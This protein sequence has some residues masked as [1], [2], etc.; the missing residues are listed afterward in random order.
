[1]KSQRILSIICFALFLATFP[2]CSRWRTPELSVVT[3]TNPLDADKS[4]IRE[5]INIE[6]KPSGYQRTTIKKTT[7]DGG[8][9]A[10]QV[11]QETVVIANRLSEKMT[12]RIEATALQKRD[13]TF[14]KGQ[15][16][17][18]LDKNPMITLFVPDQSRTKLD[19]LASTVV[20]DPKTGGET[21]TSDVANRSIA[22]QNGTAGHFALYFSLWNNPLQPEE[23]RSVSYFD[24][25]FEQNVSVELSAGRISP[26]LL[27]GSEIYLLLVKAV[28]NY[29]T[30]SGKN[31][32]TWQFWMD[33]KGNMVRTVSQK[34]QEI[35]WTLS[36]ESKVNA[37]LKNAGNLNL[38]LY[39]IVPVQGKIP[40]PRETKRVAFL[41]QYV[42]A[43]DKQSM[44]SGF[45]E[46]I[47][48]TAFQTV[49]AENVAAWTVA[50]TGSSPQILSD[51]YGSVIP[52]AEKETS[53]PGDL[54]R[55]EWIQS[56]DAAVTGLANIATEKNFP[57]WD[58]ATD[59]E[60]FVHEKMRRVNYDSSLKSA[61]EA[62]KTLTGDSAAHA[63][64]LAALAR[65]KNI[66]SRIVAGLVYTNTSTGEGVLV[67][68]FWTELFI[69]E[70]WRP[71]D[72]TLGRG[73]A[74]ASR[75]VLARSNLAD[76]SISSLIAPLLPLVGHLQTIVI[77]AE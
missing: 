24:L 46:K 45:A 68:H 6:G 77:K 51:L 34:P 75:I 71:F 52:P 14:L 43:D 66:P 7:T 20:I 41:L 28:T 5:L 48:S 60:K 17:L 1:M 10:Y 4:E 56:D 74:D 65:A 35:E 8:E 39:A 2:A 72:A 11:S 13:G 23:K 9:E 69:D 12:G 3:A 29:Q 76:Q 18:Q 30:Q 26:F 64:L 21:P 58:V 55:N 63:V 61:G 44:P 40:Q 73:G 49:K 33:A 19:R 36:P 54:A 16:T 67:L 22:W 59:I 32:L 37:A 27:N 31:S 57:F 15:K 70:H 50:I 25:L 53:T 62:A 42:G 47:P 38:S